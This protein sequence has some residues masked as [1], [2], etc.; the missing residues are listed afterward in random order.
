MAMT[1]LEMAFYQR[2]P[3]LLNNICNQLERIANALEKPSESPADKVEALDDALAPKK[4]E[5]FDIISEIRN[6]PGRFPNIEKMLMQLG[7]KL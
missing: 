4:D 2:V 5:P 7:H 3:H 1:N 6:N